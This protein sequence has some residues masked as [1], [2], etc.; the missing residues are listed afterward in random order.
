MKVYHKKPIR[1]AT[2]I[3]YDSPQGKNNIFE[4]DFENPASL[5]R[6][7]EDIAGYDFALQFQDEYEAWY[8]DEVASVRSIVDDKTK[9]A[10]EDGDTCADSLSELRDILNSIDEYA[11]DVLDEDET[12]LDYVGKAL[13]K[14]DDAEDD[15][16]NT[17]GGI[18][19]LREELGQE[20]IY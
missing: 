8:A 2:T 9:E 19:D 16:S 14:L 5:F 12:L 6:V 13:E 17:I 10:I 7:L 18:N 3:R 4:L 15:I 1:S 11:T 20:E